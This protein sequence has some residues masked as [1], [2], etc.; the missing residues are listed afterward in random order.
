MPLT[1]D[2]R[3]AVT[4]AAFLIGAAAL[5]RAAAPGAAP[6]TIDAPAVDLAAQTHTAEARLEEARSRAPARGAPGR[7]A[8]APGRKA[9]APEPLSAREPWRDLARSRGTAASDAVAP[10]S[11]APGASARR[12]AA[13]GEAK[14]A[15]PA[16]D[17]NTATAQQLEAL[18]G[19]GP[20]LASRIISYRDSAGPFETLDDL[21]RIRGIGARTLAR[22]RPLLRPIP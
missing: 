8:A 3:R 19:I 4:F 20:A 18:P 1:S 7:E 21:I 9:A 15:A 10:R 13:P 16:V 22:L 17:V 6:A 11:A 5:V 12:S 14:R 2:E